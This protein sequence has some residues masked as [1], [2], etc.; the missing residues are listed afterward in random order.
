VDALIGDTE[1]HRP[2][3]R[4]TDSGG[5][6]EQW[7]YWPERMERRWKDWPWTIAEVWELIACA[8]IKGSE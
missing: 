2:T 7:L 5:S 8:S 3:D 4:P 6:A 1:I